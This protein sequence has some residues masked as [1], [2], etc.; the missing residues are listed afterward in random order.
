[1]SLVWYASQIVGIIEWLVDAEH[2]CLGV[3][4]SLRLW[5]SSGPPPGA[6]RPIV[7]AC[8]IISEAAQ[9][10]IGRR[11]LKWVSDSWPQL[12]G[13]DVTLV[14]IKIGRFRM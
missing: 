14:R 7:P 3:D 10:F 1:M 11:W 5:K 8:S 4:E 13:P 2:L 9:L 12:V 6:R